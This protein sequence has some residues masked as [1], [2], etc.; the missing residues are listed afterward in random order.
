[1]T[2]PI[3]RML[4]D[5]S[6]CRIVTHEVAVHWYPTPTATTCHCGAST[7]CAHDWAERGGPGD[8]WLECWLCGEEWDL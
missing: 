2:A 4:S 5:P 3:D 7:R 8:E 6:R 1:M